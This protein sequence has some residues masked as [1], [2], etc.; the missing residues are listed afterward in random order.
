M[1]VA[2]RLLKNKL[3]LFVL[4]S[5]I[6]IFIGIQNV[7][8]EEVV[9][10]AECAYS[11]EY[12]NIKGSGPIYVSYTQLKDSSGKDYKLKVR[13]DVNKEHQDLEDIKNYFGFDV[14]HDV[15]SNSTFSVA[16]LK[17]NAC[18]KYMSI[19]YKD[20][21]RNNYNYMALFY[22]DLNESKNCSDST[23]STSCNAYF[24]LT[25]TYK[26]VK[27][28]PDEVQWSIY[29]SAESS[30]KFCSDLT[31]NLLIQ[32]NQICAL[33]IYGKNTK[34]LEGRNWTSAMPVDHVYFADIYGLAINNAPTYL[35]FDP[36]D[37]NDKMDSDTILAFNTTTVTFEQGSKYEK[38]K[39]DS[40]CSWSAN[41]KLSLGKSCITPENLKATLD[42]LSSRANAIYG[43]VVDL[44]NSFTY[45]PNN[46]GEARM[47]KTFEEISNKDTLINLVKKYDSFKKPNKEESDKVIEELDAIK[48][49]TSASLSG[50]K[51]CQDTKDKVD[52][53]LSTLSTSADNYA[54][55]MELILK[56]VE[57]ARNRL[58]ELGATDEELANVDETINGIKNDI[59]I[60][61]DFVERAKTSMLDSKDFKLDPSKSSGCG[62]FSG[63]MKDFLNTVL[64]YIRIGAVVLAIILSLVDYI[65][66]ASGSDDKSMSAANKKFMTRVM[67]VAVLFLVP[68]LLE[69]VL[70][71]LNI[72][73][74]AGSLECLK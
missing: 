21:K 69:F 63:E 67:L 50:N 7:K 16:M 48:N 3:L 43:N 70:N 37:G 61:K 52:S 53:I 24:K 45:K 32:N 40:T 68:V 13:L 72:S 71:L 6:S 28:N 44:K 14:N 33:P 41:T 36:D 57:N 46:S 27:V 51:P 34:Y 35:T 56:G 25:E 31:V 4:L 29:S 74:T 54:K 15:K 1:K 5:T 20:G 26:Y 66:A 62:V 73:T 8:A 17:N 64:W 38:D 18:P 65:K 55:D 9:M 58:A 59:S 2:N 49:G 22:N 19:E 10:Y 47:A 23:L 11:L 39:Y 30:S 60:A 42:S 12:G